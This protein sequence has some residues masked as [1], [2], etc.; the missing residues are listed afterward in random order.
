MIDGIATGGLGAAAGEAVERSDAAVQKDDFLKLLVAQIEQQDPME[1][2]G[3]DQF[4]QQLTQFS[5]LEQLMNV[6]EGLGSLALG[7]LSNNHQ[8]ALRFVGQDVLARGDAVHWD[9]HEAPSLSYSVGE[10]A[11]G[12]TSA[13][14]S[15][16]DED[17]GLVRT[18]S[19]DVTAGPGDYRWDG[20]N[21]DGERMVA[22]RYRVRVS[23]D[24]GE[25]GQVPV[26]THVRGRVNGVRF[27]Q[28]YPELIIGDG[29]GERRAAISDVVEVSAGGGE[30]GA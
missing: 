16:F 27:D 17:G 26:D 19:I 15:V 24:D 1:P 20:R 7:Q 11:D 5:M 6:N 30:G 12:V 21:D 4:M 10:L 23:V 28:G 25:G 9:G 14:V 13:T 2:E 29:D 3:S 8:Q 18:E 22:G